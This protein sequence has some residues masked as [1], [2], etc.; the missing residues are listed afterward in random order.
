[1]SPH[2]WGCV[3]REYQEESRR[4][5]EASR[6]LIDSYG[7]AGR[8]ELYQWRAAALAKLAREALDKSFRS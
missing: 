4:N 3:A 1:M 5:Y 7:S 6:I 2:L 8:R